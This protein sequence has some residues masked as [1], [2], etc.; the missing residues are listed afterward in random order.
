MERYA[1]A[2]NRHRAPFTPSLSALTLVAARGAQATLAARGAPVSSPVRLARRPSTYQALT[3]ALPAPWRAGRPPSSW[4][5]ARRRPDL[6][7]QGAGAEAAREAA[8]PAVFAR[9]KAAAAAVVGRRHT[10][11]PGRVGGALSA[12]VAAA[13][14]SVGAQLC[15]RDVCEWSSGR[16][17][18]SKSE[19]LMTRQ[20]SVDVPSTLTLPYTVFRCVSAP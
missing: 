1:I 17:L 11:R 13:V 20:R 9:L 16:A 5:R 7:R 10:R 2:S 12:A 15:V 18:R 19:C 8:P 6:D 14:W 3:C 4:R